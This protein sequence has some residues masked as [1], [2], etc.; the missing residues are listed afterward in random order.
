LPVLGIAAR[1]P[2][3]TSGRRLIEIGIPPGPDIESILEDVREATLAG[4]VI[5]AVEAEDLALRIFRG[6]R[7]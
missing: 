5:N 2:A 4:K 7:R 6:S 1:R 3:L